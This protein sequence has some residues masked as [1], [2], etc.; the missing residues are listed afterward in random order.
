MRFD[1]KKKY[2]SGQLYRPA[3]FIKNKADAVVYFEELVEYH[4]QEEGLTIDEKEVRRNIKDS[5]G[6]FA[7]YYD[8]ETRLRVEELFECAHPMFG[9]AKDGT[10]S[11]EEALKKGMDFAERG[12]IPELD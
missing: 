5:L 10:P 3:I 8:D 7:G 1:P 2:T 6:Y 4:L 12:D 9:K 11:I